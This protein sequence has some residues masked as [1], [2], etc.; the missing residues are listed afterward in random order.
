MSRALSNRIRSVL[1][2]HNPAECQLYFNDS[3]YGQSG[4][5]TIQRNRQY[6]HVARRELPETEAREIERLSP[7]TP[8]KG[9]K[10]S[11][12]KPL[13]EDRNAQKVA[14]HLPN[15]QALSFQQI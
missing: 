6:N 15:P 5:P 7:Q 4:L 10:P 12:A 1:G 9:C 3:D 11:S 14:L 8:P 2:A 13:S